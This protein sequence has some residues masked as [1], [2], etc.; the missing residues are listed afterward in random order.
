MLPSL[1]RAGRIAIDTETTGVEV[2]EKP[3][4]VGLSIATES[5]IKGYFCWGHYRGGNNTTLEAVRE[6]AGT[7]LTRTDQ[8]K[9]FFNAAFDL[10][11]LA[12]AGIP[13][14]G[15]LGYRGMVRDAAIA[16]VLLDEFG[17][18]RLEDV[19][20][21]W[22][23][24]GKETEV[25]KKLSD[26]FGGPPTRDQQI[27]RM[28][29]APG[30]MI[31]P[32]A[33]QDA[34]LTLKLERHL[35]KEID[36][37]EGLSWTY[38]LESKIIPIV[39]RLHAQ[40]VPVSKNAI[41]IV[42]DKVTA[43]LKDANDQWHSL[44]GGVSER[45]TKEL[46]AVYERE[47]I[48]VP[49]TKK[50]NLSLS[51]E[52]LARPEFAAHPITKLLDERRTL[53]AVRDTFIRNY[54][55]KGIELWDHHISDDISIIHGLFHQVANETHGTISG[56]FSSGG[57]LNLQNIPSRNKVLAPLVR[58]CFVPLPGYKWARADFSQIEYR[59]LAH[60]A[61]GALRRAYLDDPLVD[62]HA[63]TAELSGLER[64]DAK[65]INFAVVYGAGVK[66]M[67]SQLGASL[68]EAKDF[69]SIY[70]AQIPEVK[71]MRELAMRRAAQKGIVR[72]WG[73]RRRRF[74]KDESGRYTKTHVGLNALLQGSAA[75]LMKLKMIE[76]ADYIDW[77][78]CVM[79]L[80]IHDELDFSV[81][82]SDAG[83][84]M[85]LDIRD[86]MQYVRMTDK[87]DPRRGMPIEKTF[88]DGPSLTVPMLVDVE[89]G[90]DWGSAT[91]EEGAKFIDVGDRQEVS[92][93]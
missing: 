38:D 25:Y 21:E 26:M 18:R 39:Y 79:H 92:G 37:L 24:E 27:G 57:G 54:L 13:C 28:W 70:D 48:K 51:K 15:L 23:G 58:G 47:G 89:V 59:F 55:Y 91:A 53:L 10:R 6:W 4:P 61:G 9:V 41:Q 93:T 66:K 34:V 33:I 75:D 56:R 67:A 60:Y 46:A 29:K 82:P 35:R 69:L 17:P 84:K 7:E 72:T 1:E 88:R 45:S 49:R 44:T 20:L 22:L 19:G 40:G 85:L 74:R 50:G 62:F 12:V 76:V 11:M 16:A 43:S 5:G 36:K 71:K 83:R 30:D 87:V 31:A 8:T 52:V 42:E 3:R 77:D 78:E 32:Y 80:T 90:D 14:T 64:K 63:F 86:M 2:H 65:G 68:K 81:S 73:E